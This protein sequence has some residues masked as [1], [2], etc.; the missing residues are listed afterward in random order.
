M[1]KSRHAQMYINVFL[2]AKENYLLKSIRNHTYEF[3]VF[4]IYLRKYQ[5]PYDLYIYMYIYIYIYIH[6]YIYIYICIYMYVSIEGLT[7]SEAKAA[8]LLALLFTPNP[9]CPYPLIPTLLTPTPL[10]HTSLT[11]TYA[12]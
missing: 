7:D 8:R 9:P 3:F 5:M 4:I 6:I 1:Y 10:T 12:V 11:L 2:S